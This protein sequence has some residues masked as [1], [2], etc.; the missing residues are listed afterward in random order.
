MEGGVLLG[1]ENL[2]QRARRVAVVGY[3]YLV[4]LVEDDDR[5]RR[6]AALDRLDDAAGHGAYVCA[7]VSPDLGL[8]VQTA[9]RNAA[10]L[11]AERSGD[12]LA[13]RRLAHARRAVEAENRRF[14]V[15]FE[16]DDGQMLH[17]SLLDFVQTE[18]VVV[19]L[20]A[21]LLQ[22]EI[23]GR[24][25]VPRQFQHELQIVHLHGVLRHGGIEPFEFRELLFEELGRRLRPLLLRGLLAHLVY[26]G[27]GAVAYLVLNSPQLLLQIVVALLLVYLALDLFLNRIFKL[28]QLLLPYQY[29]QQLARTRQQPRSLQQRLAVVVREFDVRADEV[30]DAAAR[31]DV[32]DRESRLLGHRGRYVDDVERHLADRVDQRAEFDVIG[33]GRTVADHPYRRLEIWV[34]RDVVAHLDLLQTVEYDRQIAVGHLQYLQYA[35]CRTDLI[36]IVGGGR[37][38]IAVALQHGSEQTARGVDLPYQRDALLAADGNGRYG[39]RKYNRAAKRKY[40]HYLRYCYLFDRVVAS[41]D[42]R[43]D[44]MT[45]VEQF[46]GKSQ[47]FNLLIFFTHIPYLI[48]VQR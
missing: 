34:G 15:A 29:L 37:F 24:G 46:G 42:D 21:R 10:E 16:F 23:V 30:D 45:A 4:H 27:I 35:G 39:T 5:I 28:D 7:A 22:V 36:H 6:A 26:L 20:A 2:Q 48:F 43:N 19:E 18:M 11:A 40:G 9:Q 41:R 44:L 17:Q 31:I 25:M 8:V 38:D 32:L 47:I 1:I 14:E 33:V 12:R 13:Q 3:G